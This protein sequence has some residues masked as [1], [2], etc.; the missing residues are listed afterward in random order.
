MELWCPCKPREYRCAYS[1]V[2]TNSMVPKVW[3]IIEGTELFTQVEDTNG[4]YD[5][6]S[7]LAEMIALLGPPPKGV[8]ERADHMSQVDFPTPIR[9]EAG[10]LSKNARELFGGPY[11]DEEGK[12]STRRMSVLTDCWR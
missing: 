8:I 6:K 5:A 11:F 9:I 10:K 12:S 2:K 4:R 7:H 1:A 3:N